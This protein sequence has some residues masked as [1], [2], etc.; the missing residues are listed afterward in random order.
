MCVFWCKRGYQSSFATMLSF[1]SIKVNNHTPESSTPW[2]KG[3]YTLWK[4]DTKL[5]NNSGKESPFSGFSPFRGWYDPEKPFP[6]FNGIVSK[7]LLQWEDIEKKAILFVIVV[8]VI[9]LLELILTNRDLWNCLPQKLGL[10]P[11]VSGL[12][13]SANWQR[14][15][16]ICSLQW[17]YLG[18]R[19]WWFQGTVSKFHPKT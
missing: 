7:L 12:V 2:N 5:K 18:C 14:L 19:C 4:S 15:P 17:G 9:I 1:L 16:W 10:L 13:L 8:H 6:V 3:K 11:L